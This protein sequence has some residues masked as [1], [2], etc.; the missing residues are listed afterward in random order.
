MLAYASRIDSTAY[1][2]MA[3]SIP[4]P[5]TAQQRFWADR[6]YGS[7]AATKPVDPRSGWE[8]YKAALRETVPAREPAAAI[9]AQMAG[10][11]GVATAVAAI[12]DLV[13]SRR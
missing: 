8:A 2:T 10:E 13:G 1:S 6:L 9:A 3:P 12:Q 7:G 5:F 4:V 11:D